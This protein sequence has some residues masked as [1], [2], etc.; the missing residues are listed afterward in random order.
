MRIVFLEF[1]DRGISGGLGA[2]LT[3]AK[4]PVFRG[5]ATAGWDNPFVQLLIFDIGDASAS[6]K[7]SGEKKDEQCQFF[8]TGLLF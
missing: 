2:F 5:G 1:F 4:S 6:Q 7:G 3:K 8:Q